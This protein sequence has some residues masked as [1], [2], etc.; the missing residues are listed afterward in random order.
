MELNYMKSRLSSHQRSLL[1]IVFLVVGFGGL[2]SAVTKALT[3]EDGRSVTQSKDGS[4]TV[5]GC[6]SE[7]DM[8]NLFVMTGP[9][10]YL[11]KSSKVVL[12]DH[13]GHKVTVAG[14]I[15]EDYDDEDVSPEFREGGGKLLIVSSLKMISNKCK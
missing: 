8:E 10:M 7:A 13:V 2:A 5:T 3:R 6:I 11:L 1:L 9:K 4:I 14:T 15:K 12:K